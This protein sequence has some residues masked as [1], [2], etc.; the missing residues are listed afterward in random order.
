MSIVIP[1]AVKKYGPYLAVALLVVAILALAYCQGKS[2]GAKDEQ[3]NTAENTI[4]VQHTEAAAQEAAAEQRV[5]DVLTLAEQEKELENAR[6]IGAHPSELR[7]RRACIVM[8]QQDRSAGVPPE[9]ER[10]SAGS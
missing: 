10:F 8:Q 2:H 5:R 7:A 9:C 4:E 3:L 1:A 6:K